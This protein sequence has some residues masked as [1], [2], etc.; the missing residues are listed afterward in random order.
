M[1][2]RRPKGRQF[3][4]LLRCC[5]SFA[6]IFHTFSTFL[7]V[8]MVRFSIARAAHLLRRFF[9][10]LP[11]SYKYCVKLF[12]CARC[13]AALLHTF[14]A[15]FS[16]LFPFL[17][18]TGVKVFH[19]ARCSAALLHTFCTDFSHFLLL[20]RGTGVKVFYCVLQRC[21]AAHFLRRF[22]TFPPPSWRYRC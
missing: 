12:H 10:F 18:C 1:K 20:L 22:F 6:Q 16:H 19:C 8:Q 3:V 15:D 14:C 17:A 5:T 2:T 21:A 11:L 9:T 7:E 13:S 4:S